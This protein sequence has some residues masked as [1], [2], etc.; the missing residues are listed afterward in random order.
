MDFPLF[1]TAAMVFM[2]CLATALAAWC[3]AGKVIYCI[4]A[5]WRSETLAD[6]HSESLERLAIFFGVPSAAQSRTAASLTVPRLWKSFLRCMESR[7]AGYLLMFLW[8]VLTGCGVVSGPALLFPSF[9][10]IAT[11][12][13]VLSL[14]RVIVFSSDKDI[15]L[16]GLALV[17]LGIFF[18]SLWTTP[19]GSAVLAKINTQGE[20]SLNHVKF[21]LSWGLALV[22]SIFGHFANWWQNLRWV[23]SYLIPISGGSTLFAGLPNWSETQ[24]NWIALFAAI[25]L[26]ITVWNSWRQRQ[27]IRERLS[28]RIIFCFALGYAG[29]LAIYAL[30]MIDRDLGLLLPLGTSKPSAYLQMLIEAALYQVPVLGYWIRQALEYLVPSSAPGLVPGITVFALDQSVKW[31]IGAVA[32]LLAISGTILVVQKGVRS[33]IGGFSD[34]V[35]RAI[36]GELFEKASALANEARVAGDAYV[37]AVIRVADESISGRAQPKEFE[38]I[39]GG[40]HRGLMAPLLGYLASSDEIGRN[41]RSGHTI[42]RSFLRHGGHLIREHLYARTRLY[43]PMLRNHL[44]VTPPGS[45]S[46]CIEQLRQAVAEWNERRAPGLLA[47]LMALLGVELSKAVAEQW[48]DDMSRLTRFKEEL[49]QAHGLLVDAQRIFEQRMSPIDA[50]A[51]IHN[52]GLVEMMLARISHDAARADA[53]VRCFVNALNVRDGEYSSGDDLSMDAA[54][55]HLFLALSLGLHAR[56]TGDRSSAVRLLQ[57]MEKSREIYERNAGRIVYARENLV[58]ASIHAG[59]LAMFL[60]HWLV[61]RNHLMLA[62]EHSGKA[63]L[64]GAPNYRFGILVRRALA[65]LRMVQEELESGENSSPSTGERA[66]RWLD[67]ATA[68]IK[69]LVERSTLMP[70]LDP[71][72]FDAMRDIRTILQLSAYRAWMKMELNLSLRNAQYAPEECIKGMERALAESLQWSE[73]IRRSQVHT[74][75]ADEIL[76]LV[77]PLLGC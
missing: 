58:I 24:I 38:A 6:L 9:E 42:R 62:L 39:D 29:F 44:A 32:T 27:R 74:G 18:W 37:Q 61:A 16:E 69:S 11:F 66:Q 15:F 75:N 63:E 31:W 43:W 72:S 26:I 8:V 50:A 67:D 22:I 41:S 35:S 25:L 28:I 65:T 30:A 59:N 21:A 33:G 71:P 7:A 19:Y 64:R 73:R 56:I 23:L 46:N 77:E 48:G 60:D 5:V 55:S 49:L 2:M 40:Q 3:L 14:L 68:D 51:I 52:L 36:N 34:K 12:L 10:T 47:G 1:N 54:A 57:H 53:A 17:A 20:V 70:R 45:L 4:V 13:A 76:A